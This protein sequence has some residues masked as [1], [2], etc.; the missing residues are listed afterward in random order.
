MPPTGTPPGP[1]ADRSPSPPRVRADWV[2]PTP[3]WGPI[4]IGATPVWPHCRG[5]TTILPSLLVFIGPSGTGKSSVVRGLADRG[6]VTVHPTWT[7]RPRRRDELAGS[8]EHHFVSEAEFLRR[9]D[10]GFFLHSVQMFGMP[11][12]YGLPTIVDRATIRRTH[13]DAAGTA[14]PDPAV[15]LLRPRDLPDRR[16]TRRRRVPARNARLRSGRARRAARRQ[17][18]RAR[19][20]PPRRRTAISTTTARS[21]SSSTPSSTPSGATSLPH[22]WRRDER[23]P[24]V[25][26][27]VTDTAA[28]GGPA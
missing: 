20:G 19:R 17:R 14:R 2:P 23:N 8:V 9:R 6:V 7:T 1:E 4:R 25:T 15:G 26:E 13:G 5:M 10:D 16:A 3:R 22:S 12:W 21:T 18:A 27:M 28:Q 24:T 11:Y